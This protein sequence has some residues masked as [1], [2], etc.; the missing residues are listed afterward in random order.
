MVAGWRWR[1]TAGAFRKSRSRGCL[2]RRSPRRRAARVWAS[3]SRTG[4]SRAGGEPSSSRARWGG[5][6]PSR[7]GFRRAPPADFVTG[8]TPGVARMAN[9]INLVTGTL[10][11][12]NRAHIGRGVRAR[13]TRRRLHGA[14][15]RAGLVHR[16][17]PH[18]DGWGF[19]RALGER[20][21]LQPRLPRGPRALGAGG[22]AQAD[23][24][25]PARPD[26]VLP[27]SS[28]FPARARP[29][30]QPRLG[31]VQPNPGSGLRAE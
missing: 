5:E 24:P 25:A 1:T 2:S 26:P 17:P 19:G 7:S 16:R 4:W 12:E 20:A 8:L 31:R 29:D 3:P 23:D 6:R 22:P 18:R 13:R 9:L 10:L 27:R 30:V 21:P 15:R 28:H 14:R 11:G